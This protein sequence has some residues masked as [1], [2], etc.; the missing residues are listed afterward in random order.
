MKELERKKKAADAYF[1]EIM[2]KLV[3]TIDF[4]F[5]IMGVATWLCV[6]NVSPRTQY[7]KDLALVLTGWKL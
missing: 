4:L 3:R 5:V 2:K 7:L 1:V 6:T